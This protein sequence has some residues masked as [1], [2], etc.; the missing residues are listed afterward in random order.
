MGSKAWAEETETTGLATRKT[1]FTHLAS[2]PRMCSLRRY[3]KKDRKTLE[4]QTKRKQHYLDAADHLPALP[5]Q[6]SPIS[7]GLL[8]GTSSPPERRGQ[9]SVGQFH[10]K[11][12]K[13][14]EL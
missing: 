3:I 7:A 6:A 10:G 13:D 12:H 2:S 8:F 1:I 4:P 14:T 5:G 9:G 11:D